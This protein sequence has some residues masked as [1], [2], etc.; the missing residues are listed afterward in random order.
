VSTPIVVSAVL[1]DG[2]DAFM[3]ERRIVLVPPWSRDPP[4]PS[5]W[6]QGHDNG[7]K[8]QRT[9]AGKPPQMESMN[10]HIQERRPLAGHR[11]A[12]SA[13]GAGHRRISSH[14]A[15]WSGRARHAPK[16]DARVLMITEGTYPYAV[17]GVSSWCEVLIGGLDEMQ[18]QIL[19]VVAG[20]RR[21]HQRFTLPSNA[22]LLR[23]IE[24]WSE[25]RAPRRMA[26]GDKR[27]DVSLPIR[28]LKGLMPWRGDIDD[29]TEAL[30]RCREYPQTIRPEF[31]ARDNWKEY[32]W[33]LDDVLG[34]RHDDSAPAPVFDAIEAARLYQTLYWVAR[35]AAVPT[36]PC[37]LLHVTAAGWA[38]IPALVH[39]ALHGTPLL[40]TEHGVYVREAYLAS[41]REAA[42]TPGQGHISPRLALGLTRATY[43]AADVIAP[44][45]EANAAWER[46]LGVDPAKIRVIPNGIH[47]PTERTDPPNA[48]KVIAMGRIDP[49]KDVQTMLLVADEVTRRMP[50]ARFEYWGPATA[51]QE[52]YARACTQMHE[53][54]QLGDRFRFM[55]RTS[56]PHGVIRSGDLVLMTSISEAMPMALLE[57]MAQSRPAVATS[58][59]GVPGV[60]RGCGIIAPP[61]DVHALATAVVTLLG[62]PEL[63]ANLGRRGFE[64]LHRRYTLAR[65]LTGYRDLI[66]GLIGEAAA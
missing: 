33:A 22:R 39:K 45:T 58:V 19:P 7:Y 14:G 46:G 29:L 31:R 36:P 48:R 20:G 66:S 23:P 18:W 5:C 42:M 53:Q 38:A 28:L 47:P 1:I 30:V 9:R 64:R 59:G 24:L 62:N 17:G 56:D 15:A 51:G 60:L 11:T 43:A 40:L 65:C 52:T 4:R 16:R 27:P 44:V 34:E 21:M 26:R 25:Q 12:P 32:L 2:F 55:G 54:L 37:E 61:G 50:D 6:A 63:A 3:T 57:A 35:T 41:V 8:D 49:L 13:T 10:T